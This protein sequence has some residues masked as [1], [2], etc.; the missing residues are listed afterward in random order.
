M[1]IENHTYT[2]KRDLAD[3]LSQFLISQMKKM[4]LNYTKWQLQGWPPGTEQ[5]RQINKNVLY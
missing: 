3:H 4:R 2:S 5:G 1:Y